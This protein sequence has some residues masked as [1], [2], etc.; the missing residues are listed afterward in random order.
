MFQASIVEN[1][2]HFMFKNFL[3]SCCLWDNVEKILYCRAG[4]RWQ[5]VAYALH[6]GYLRLQIH[7]ILCNTLFF[8]CNNGCTNAP[9]CNVIGK[10][11]VFLCFKS[12]TEQTEIIAIQK[13]SSFVYITERE[14]VY[15]AVR[16]GSVNIILVGFCLQF[17][18]SFVSWDCKYFTLICR[19]Y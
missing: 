15:C 16:L 10:L 18:K 17:L 9:E 2:T 6:A 11:L 1:L 3:K 4:H 7:I 14:C 12:I 13:I 5:Y 19:G 8:H